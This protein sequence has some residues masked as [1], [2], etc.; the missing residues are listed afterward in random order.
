MP[1]RVPPLPLLAL[2]AVLAI[3]C[4]SAS[5]QDRRGDWRERGGPPSS[6]DAGDMLQPRRGPSREDGLSD[7]VRR[8]ERSSRGQVL[9]AE[10]M[11]S[12]GRDVNRIKVVDGRGRVRVYMDDP[13]QGGRLPTRD[14]DD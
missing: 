7:S 14:D 3:G 6:R 4:A 5:A 2:T 12:D 10:R 9:S 1:C 13:Q 11:Q 8:I